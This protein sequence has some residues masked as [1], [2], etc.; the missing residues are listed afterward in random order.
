MS[1]N[2]YHKESRCTQPIDQQLCDIAF[3]VGLEF[4]GSLIPVD[5]AHQKCGHCADSDVNGA[6]EALILLQYKLTNSK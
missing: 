2:E 6:P 4:R 3:S 1:T 5:F